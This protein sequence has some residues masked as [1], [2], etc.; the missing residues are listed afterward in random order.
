MIIV[1]VLL[2][3]VFCFMRLSSK[4]ISLAFSHSSLIILNICLRILSYV[5]FPRSCSYVFPFHGISLNTSSPKL[6]NLGKITSACPILL[7][8]VTLILLVCLILLVVCPLIFTIRSMYL[9]Y[10][11]AFRITAHHHTVLKASQKFLK[12]HRVILFSV[13]S[14][15]RTFTIWRYSINI[16]SLLKHSVALSV[17][18]I[19]IS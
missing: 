7:L 3:I 16:I 15:I 4:S 6:N 8:T 13:I 19:P 11:F 12:A 17:D 5:I 10:I 18:T 9:E 1:S 14:S 2:F